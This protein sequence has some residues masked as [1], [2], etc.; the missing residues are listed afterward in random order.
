ML[1]FGF[2]T[3]RAKRTVRPRSGRPCWRGFKVKRKGLPAGRAKASIKTPKLIV[4]YLSQYVTGITYKILIIILFLGSI[5]TIF[6]SEWLQIKNIALEGN[7]SVDQKLLLDTVEPYL[8]KNIISIFPARNIFFVPKKK[9]EKE[10]KENFRRVAEVKIN[11]NFPNTLLITI[12]EKESVLLFCSDKGCVWVDETGYAY[13][14]SSFA[15]AVIDT[16]GVT[17]V[18]DSSHSDI[19]LGKTITTPEYVKY[20]DVL[21]KEFPARL[22]K[23]INHFSIPIPSAQ[24]VRVHTEEN[25]VVY[26]NTEVD[27]ERSLDLLTRVVLQEFKNKE[28]DLNCLEYIDLRVTDKVFYKLKEG[29]G[30]QEE[31]E[32]ENQNSPEEKKEKDKKEE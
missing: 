30:I 9:I 6:F 27:I 15:E 8:H 29:C 28:L 22:E 25:W 18:Q 13:N 1:T 5:Y 17:I 11:K 26:L 32:V 2:K 31:Q 19:E 20:I 12:K 7:Q 14:R 23:N 16:T 3:K 4:S 10:I 21:K 24:E